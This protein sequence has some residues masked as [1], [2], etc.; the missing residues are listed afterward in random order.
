MVSPPKVAFKIPVIWNAEEVKRFLEVIKGDRWSAIYYLGCGTGMRKGEIL[1]LPLS[2]LDL[3]KGYLMVVQ[4]LQLVDN[5]LAL[6]EPK[7][8]KS[9]RLIVLPDFVKEALKIHLVR[10]E[11]LSQSVSWKESGL[12]F[13]T[14]IGTPISPRNMVRHFKT[15]LKE[16]GL[17]NIKFHSLRHGVASLLLERNVHPKI[18]SELLGHSSVNL[19]LSTYSHIINP[20]NKVASSE[21]DQIFKK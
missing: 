15:K 10:R 5:K 8:Q 17:P 6:M 3:D 18:V 19:T 11:V 1:G 21:M 7:T 13:T 16:A 2:A 20:I 12:V 9:R 14:D 4:T